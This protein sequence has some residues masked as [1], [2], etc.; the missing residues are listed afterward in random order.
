ME[1]EEEQIKQ[2][3]KEAFS[4]KN[5]ISKKDLLNEFHNYEITHSTQL[6]K[7][8]YLSSV[9][10][11]QFK[12]HFVDGTLLERLASERLNSNNKSGVKGVC[13]CKKRGKDVWKAS[14]TF[15]GKKYNKFF[16]TREEAISYRNELENTIVKPF[17]EQCHA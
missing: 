7:N 16:N 10:Q 6:S 17:L 2:I 11:D 5:K 14:L 4:N 15:K 13:L 9:T 12:L 3:L 1:L 8:D